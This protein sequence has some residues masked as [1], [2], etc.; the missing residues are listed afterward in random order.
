QRRPG[1]EEAE[2]QRVHLALAHDAERR[3][4]GAV[5]G[6][7]DVE[8]AAGA[9]AGQAD[10]AEVDVALVAQ[11]GPDGLRLLR[12]GPDAL[13]ADLVVGLLQPL[14]GRLQR[15]HLRLGPS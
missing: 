7:A 5:D 10:G 2:R 3:A 4:R 11:A 1:Q 15:L 14:L 12:E 8:R 13:V 6:A 9:A